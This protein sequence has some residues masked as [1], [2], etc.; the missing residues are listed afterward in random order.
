MAKSRKK[1]SSTSAML[2]VA[3][4]LAQHLKAEKILLMAEVGVRRDAILALHQVCST[5]IV[6]PN[7][8]FLTGIED[9]GIGRLT[10]D[11]DVDVPMYNQALTV[12]RMSLRF[13]C[14]IG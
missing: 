4:D 10:F 2:E 1:V 11:F 6:T 7:K 9:F 8:R 14:S 3:I 13:C 12:A 5:L